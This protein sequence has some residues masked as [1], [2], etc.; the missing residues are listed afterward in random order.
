MARKN[1]EI[2]IVTGAQ[3]DVGV[4]DLHVLRSDAADRSSKDFEADAV[5][6]RTLL[7][8]HFPVATVRALLRILMDDMPLRVVENV[9]ENPEVVD[10]IVKEA[11][12]KA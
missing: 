10:Q 1:P 6:V 7:R 5:V 12:E 8:R 2:Y 4:A 3:G 9:L 11:W